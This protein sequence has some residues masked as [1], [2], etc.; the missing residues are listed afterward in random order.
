M[1]Y[2][3]WDKRY[4]NLFYRFMTD[5]G[6]SHGDYG[7]EYANISCNLKKNDMVFLNSRTAQFN[8]DSAMISYNNF[9]SKF[10][11]IMSYYYGYKYTERYRTIIE[12]MMKWAPKSEP[13]KT[14][15]IWDRVEAANKGY[16]KLNEW[17]RDLIEF[18]HEME[19]M[20]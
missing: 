14:S 16:H 8:L 11:T 7:N 18:L 3:F 2:N 6:L 4:D 15:E 12:F 17:A 1:T 20:G 9:L 5:M 13:P 19:R 10:T